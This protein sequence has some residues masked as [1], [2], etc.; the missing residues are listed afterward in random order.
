MG[1]Y[2]RSMD[3]TSSTVYLGCVRLSGCSQVLLIDDMQEHI[4][5]CSRKSHRSVM[6]GTKAVDSVCIVFDQVS[7][8]GNKLCLMQ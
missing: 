8:I 6:Y 2:L 7:Y 5:N 4:Q 3:G 1:P